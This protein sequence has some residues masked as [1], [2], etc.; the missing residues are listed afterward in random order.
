[1]ES[2][3]YAAPDLPELRAALKAD[4][5]HEIDHPDSVTNLFRRLL[6]DS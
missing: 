5:D 4:L 2:P 1:M 6:G 3:A